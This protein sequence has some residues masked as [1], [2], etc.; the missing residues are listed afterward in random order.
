MPQCA[1]QDEQFSLFRQSTLTSMAANVEYYLEIER[2]EYYNDEILCKSR[3]K[4][5]LDKARSE[6]EC[7]SILGRDTFT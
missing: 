5:M 1:K 2:Q 4:R 3:G 6:E 7:C